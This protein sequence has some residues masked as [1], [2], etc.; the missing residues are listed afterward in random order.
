MRLHSIVLQV[1]YLPSNTKV[2]EKRVREV[3]LEEGTN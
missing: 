1:E 3:E 2:R